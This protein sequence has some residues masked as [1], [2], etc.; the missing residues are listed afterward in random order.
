[1]THSYINIAAPSWG[2]YPQ[3][4]SR[5]LALQW[6]HDLPDFKTESGSF[7]AYGLGRSY[8]DSCLNHGGVLL[9]TRGLKRLIDFDDQNGVL[10]CEAGVSLEEVLAFCVPR[11][12]FLPVTP[13]TQFVTVG[14]AV[15]NDVHGKNHHVAGTFGCHVL[16]LGLVRSE[17]CF[18][19][20]RHEQSELFAA[21]IGGLGLTGLITWVKFQLIP[22]RSSMMETHTTKFTSLQAFFDLSQKH[23]RDCDYSVAWIDCF[24]SRGQRTRGLFMAGNHAAAGRL[25]VAAAGR[26]AVPCD[27][28]NWALNALSIKAFNRLYY[29]RVL[30]QKILLNQGYRPF[31][32]P[33]DG[34]Q[35]WNRIYGKRGFLQFQSLTPGHDMAATQAL[36][37]AIRQAGQGSFLAVLKVFGDRR[38]PGMM[39]FPRAGVTLALDFPLQGAATFE[40]MQRLTDIVLAAGGRLYPAKDACM[41]A[42]AFQAGFPQWETFAKWVDPQF[43]SS[44]WRRVTNEKG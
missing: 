43:S 3:A 41:S 33:L 36:L 38:S 24:A 10:T 7:L 12:F 18:T 16:A 5:S 28:P 44:F 20:S 30:R 15:A 40:L 9:H 21:T 42:A 25:T 6:R 32:Y 34:V 4:D 19:C 22:I 13:G 26:L 29:H 39:S 31:F 17:G 11:G 37:Q 8:G 2:R 1:M 35:Q 14:G 23:A 27:A